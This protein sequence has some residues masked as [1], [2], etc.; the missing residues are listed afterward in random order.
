MRQFVPLCYQ[1]KTRRSCPQLHLAS[2]PIALQ[3]EHGKYRSVVPFCNQIILGH[4]GCVRMRCAWNKLLG[5]GTPSLERRGARGYA[6][7]FCEHVRQFFIAPL[8]LWK[9]NLFVYED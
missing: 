1:G 3:G 5:T 6:G 2:K 8:F 9:N 7:T 4:L